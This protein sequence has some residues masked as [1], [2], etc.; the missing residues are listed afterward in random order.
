MS[1]QT[2]SQEAQAQMTRILT[3]EKTI[4]ELAGQSKVSMIDIAYLLMEARGGKYHLLRNCAKFEEWVDKHSNLDVGTR[5]AFYCLAIVTKA[6]QMGIGREA[7]L[8]PKISVLKQIFSL[9]TEK[10][11]AEMKDMMKT[12]HKTSLD[13][14]TERVKRVRMGTTVATEQASAVVETVEKD[15][16]LTFQMTAYQAGYVEAALQSLIEKGVVSTPSEALLH[17]VQSYTT[18]ASHKQELAMAA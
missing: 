16:K 5:Q 10:Y 11:E 8:K 6:T 15:R 2:L 4:K 1:T 9:S 12:A 13:D 14:I 3:V 18:L 17:I 7:L